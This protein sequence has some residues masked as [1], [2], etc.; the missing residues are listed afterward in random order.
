MLTTAKMV[1]SYERSVSDIC[2]SIRAISKYICVQIDTEFQI[3]KQKLLKERNQTE[4]DE[5]SL[6]ESASR[7]KIN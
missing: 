4:N 3:G 1:M 2:E 7:V 5:K 6:Q